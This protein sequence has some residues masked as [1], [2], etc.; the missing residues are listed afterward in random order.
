[1]ATKILVVDDER[2]IRRF[3]SAGLGSADVDLIE[4]STGKEGVQFAASYNPDLVIVDLGLPDIDGIEVITRIREWSSVPIIVLSARGDDSNKVKALESGADDYLT[5]PFSVPD[6]RARIGAHL[7]RSADAAGDESP[8]VVFGD[9]HVDLSLHL[10]KRAGAEVHL[11]PL[12]FDLL[13]LLI[14]NAN[15]VLS[16]QLILS[17]VWGVAYA[18]HTQNLRVVMPILRL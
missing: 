16:H 11:T 13:A 9:I 17:S 12:E 15:K 10:V 8:T 1:M 18:T 6:L 14:R 2:E 7:R 3:L 4:A 5:K